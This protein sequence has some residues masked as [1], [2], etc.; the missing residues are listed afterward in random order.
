MNPFEEK[1]LIHNIDGTLQLHFCGRREKSLNHTFGPYTRKEYILSLVTEGTATLH[2]GDGIW[3]LQSGQMYVLFPQSNA[4]YIT[5]SEEPWSIR[6]IVISG[7]HV[8]FC[9]SSLGI[10]LSNPVINITNVKEI[11]SLYDSLFASLDSQ[12]LYG[13]MQSLATVYSLFARMAMQDTSYTS[14]HPAVT[15]AL[16][17]IENE[18]SSDLSVNDLAIGA[19]L[20]CPYFS[21]LFKEQL[22]TTP[23]TVITEYRLRKAERMLLHSDETVKEIALSCGYSDE[24]YFSR[25][26]KKKRGCPP[27][28]Y[29]TKYKT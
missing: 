25:L 3:Q 27:L 1:S 16:H 17:R 14:L 29:R 2:S 20:S 21:S 15:T 6:W 18:F 23:Q 12:T 22:G 4:S 10:T 28:R 19:T 11:V 24:F 26:F 13:R 8:A 9:L 5:H 7:E